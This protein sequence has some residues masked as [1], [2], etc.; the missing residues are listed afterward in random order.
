MRYAYPLLLLLV[1]GCG[2]LDGSDAKESAAIVKAEQLQTCAKSYLTKHDGEKVDSLDALVE[3][4]DD[5]E[6]ALLD[7]WGQ[8][9][10]F[11]YVTDP[12]SEQE[13][14]LIWTVVP[15]TGRVIAAPQHLSSQVPTTN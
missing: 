10:Q 2:V 4:A 15:K 3:Y 1:I 12:G 9:Y 7:P 5:G 11:A 8:A 6:Q 13:K 14:L